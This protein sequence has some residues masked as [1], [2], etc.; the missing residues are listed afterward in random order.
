M[1]KLDFQS[2]KQ[3]LS[4]TQIIQIVEDLGGSHNERLDT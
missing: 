1:E 2:F 3:S 4:E